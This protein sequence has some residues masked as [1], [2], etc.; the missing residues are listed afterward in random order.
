[1]LYI[2]ID[3]SALRIFCAS[4]LSP[5]F[6]FHNTLVQIVS[7]ILLLMTLFSALKDQQESRIKDHLTIKGDMI[8]YDLISCSSIIQNKTS[9]IVY[10]PDNSIIHSSL[11]RLSNCI[12]QNIFLEN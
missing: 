4:Y 10:V 9:E 1:M 8:Y 3:H 5:I 7:D 6:E 12:V 11:P 2:Q